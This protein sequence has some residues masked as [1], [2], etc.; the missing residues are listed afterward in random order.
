MKGIIAVEDGLPNIKNALAQEGY[1]V[2]SP[3]N[4]GKI[5]ATIIMSMQ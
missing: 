4:G 2:V 3:D 1:Q 5:G